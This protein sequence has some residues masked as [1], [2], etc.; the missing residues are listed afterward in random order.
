MRVEVKV[1]GITNKRDA[2]NALQAGANYIGFIL[3][4]KS[5]RYIT[6]EDVK[7]ISESLKDFSCQKVAVDVAPKFEDVALM[8]KA[9]FQFYQFHFPFDLE[10]K[11]IRQ[12]SEMVGPSNLWLA[13][14]LPPG[15]DFPDYLLQ[16]AETFVIDAYSQ[17]KFGGTGKSA[18]WKS[19]SEF[20]NLYP[21]K[22]W[23]LAGGIGPDNIASAY[24]KVDL[25]VVDINSS[26]ESEPGVKDEDKIKKLFLC[27]QELEK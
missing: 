26:V 10:K 9:G 7:R 18:D 24:Q 21:E 8:Q 15:A 4:P 23:I 5:P 11:I 25:Q 27:L 19:F 22:R 6:L 20:Q 1:C 3:Y 14:K 2:I 16:Y 12:W 17:H 13:P